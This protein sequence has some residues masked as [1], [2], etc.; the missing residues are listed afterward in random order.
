MAEGNALAPGIY[1]IF[2]SSGRSCLA[3]IGKRPAIEQGERNRPERNWLAPITFGYPMCD[4][5][6]W[7]GIDK[8][9][10]LEIE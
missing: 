10:R 2:W 7:D 4:E 8:V 3:A 5:W 9:E 6:M 1:R